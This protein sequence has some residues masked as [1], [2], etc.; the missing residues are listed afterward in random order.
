[1]IPL[2]LSNC[3][4]VDTF[5][6]AY[7]QILIKDDGQVDNGRKQYKEA[8]KENDSVFY[9]ECPADRGINELNNTLLFLE[10]DVMPVHSN[11]LDKPSAYFSRILLDTLFLQDGKNIA[12][13]HMTENGAAFCSFVQV[14]VD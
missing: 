5:S 11:G 6:Q 13:H 1:M 9:F 2:K 8:A 10:T 7:T 4:C 12:F 3:I 14:G